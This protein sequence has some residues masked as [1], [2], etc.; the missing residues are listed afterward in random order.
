MSDF[1]QHLVARSLGQTEGV[2][3]RLPS[4]FEVTSW[5]EEPPEAEQEEEQEAG[6][7]PKGIDTPPARRRPVSEAEPPPERTEPTPLRA[8]P[9]Q[10]EPRPEM[11]ET[12][13]VLPVEAT[14]VRRASLPEDLPRK[15]HPTVRPATAPQSRAASKARAPIA[16]QR[17]VAELA[18]PERQEGG[19]ASLPVRQEQEAVPLAPEV[20]PAVSLEPEAPPVVRPKASEE[21]SPSEKPAEPRPSAAPPPVV[22][23]R[24]SPEP[25]RAVPPVLEPIPPK[26]A[27]PA[28]ERTEKAAREAGPRLLQPVSSARVPD[29]AP[30]AAPP[31]ISVTI[32]RIEVR[33]TPPP[34]RPQPAPRPRQTAPKISLEDYLRKRSEGEF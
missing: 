23:V 19:S 16:A 24:V 28:P 13:F 15:P 10:V 6:A 11:P 22:P 34:S 4:R 8:E 12:T 26:E 9:P 2:N 17:P 21:A 3:P 30:Q 18:M 33:A 7:Q 32:G 31:M 25:P 14:S 5:R 29:S 1:L 20:R 27:A